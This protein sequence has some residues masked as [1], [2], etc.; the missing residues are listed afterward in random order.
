VG[1]CDCRDTTLRLPIFPTHW[2]PLEALR[3]CTLDIVT[4]VKGQDDAHGYVVLQ[5]LS[6]S[7]LNGDDTFQLVL[8]VDVCHV[9]N[10]SDFKHG[11]I[12]P[13]HLLDVVEHLY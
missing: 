5:R 1:S 8:L 9:S 10:V 6:C 4:N 12:G 13:T 2:T 11:M 7:L 3:R